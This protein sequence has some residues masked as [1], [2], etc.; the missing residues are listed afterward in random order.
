MSDAQLLEHEPDPEMADGIG[1][2]LTVGS[3]SDDEPTGEP[4]SNC[5]AVMEEGLLS[6]CRKC[7]F[8][9]S[10]GTFVE[11]DAWEREGVDETAVDTQPLSHLQV[12]MNLL[13]AWAWML[14]G[15]HVAVVTVSVA[16]TLVAAYGGTFRMAWSV[17]QLFVGFGAFAACHVLVYLAVISDNAEYSLLDFL[18]K[19][20]KVWAP[21]LRL[22]PATFGRVAVGTCGLNAMLMSV[23]VIAAL[24]YHVL[25]DWGIKERPKQTLVSAIV[26]HAMEAEGD[27][28]GL[29]DAIDDFA[30]ASQD[31]AAANRILEKHR[32][33]LDCLIVG[34]TT[35]EAGDE[36]Q[37]LVLAREFQG[38][39][40][41]VTRISTG[42]EDEVRREYVPKLQQFARARPFIRTATEAKWVQP[43]YTC[44]VTYLRETATGKLTEVRYDRMLGSIK[45]R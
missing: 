2:V 15:C 26:A 35:N 45:S 8:Y 42:L 1:D 34:Y 18:L 22:L 41:I 12:W 31:E 38:K 27:D 17:S 5:G 40:M 3:P 24:P 13:P 11:I 23:F 9:P 44:R 14:I 6:F 19:P 30:G 43:V 33:P 21:I 39:L 32:R 4:C 28:D 10:M 20:F 16:I 37:S 29:E 25:W 36:I 7:G